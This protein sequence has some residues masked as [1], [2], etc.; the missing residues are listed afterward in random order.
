MSLY[1]KRDDILKFTSKLFSY[2][3]NCEQYP[4]LVIFIAGL[5]PLLHYYNG[6]I[7]DATSWQQFLFL[8][9]LCFVL[10]QLILALIPLVLK[11]NFLKK[12]KSKSLSVLSNSTFLGLIGFFLFFPNKKKILALILIGIGVGWFFSKHLR[13]IIFIQ[14]ILVVINSVTFLPKLMFHLKLNNDNWTQLT[15][16]E[17]ETEFTETPNV[18]VIQPDGYVNFS[19]IDKAPYSYDNSSFKNWLVSEGFKNYEDFRSNYYS[20]YT[21]NSSMFAMKHHYYSN[22]N[23]STLKTHKANEVIVGNNNN[24]L[25][26]LKMNGY[27]SYLITD[28][29]YFLVN[30]ESMHYDYCNVKPNQVSYYRSGVLHDVD[31]MKDFNKTLDTITRHKNFFFIERTIPGHIVHKK[32]LSQGKDQERLLYIE[33]LKKANQWL[34]AIISSISNFDED[35]IIV[36]VADHGGYVGMNYTMEAV[37]RKLNKQEILSSF[38]SVLSIKWPKSIKSSNIEFKSNVNLFRN[39]FYTLSGN[40]ALIKNKALDASYLPLRD[41]SNFG[42]YKY[43]NNSGEFVFESVS[44]TN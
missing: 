1:L 15:S 22:T 11:V 28:N 40:D 24:V 25:S 34:K 17:L 6:N 39:L 13:K 36:I 42:Y 37:E 38:S 26:I 41:A 2:I 35:A 33:A 3:N 10:P 14:L 32:S 43:M 18:F 12:M 44:T 29:T 23:I 16:E 8:F 5:Y 21:S 19:E 30:R 4:V 9:S 7:Q 20:T 27:K 31:I